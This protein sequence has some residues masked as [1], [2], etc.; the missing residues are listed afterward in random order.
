MTLDQVIAG[1]KPHIHTHF[2]GKEWPSLNEMK[3][4]IVPYNSA[5]WEI[6][7]NKTMADRAKAATNPSRS[8]QQPK[9]RSQ[10]QT[11]QIKVE[12][13]KAGGTNRRFLPQD[14]FEECKKNRWCFMCKADGLKIIGSAK[15]HPNHLPQTTKN[16]DK[17]TK[18]T[19]IAAMDGKEWET[20]SCADVDSDDDYEE[21][22]KN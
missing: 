21:K 8:S 14:E 22:S 7:K 2:I 19:K 11:P 4:E 1:L 12:V 13:S 10:S 20:V 16:K 17:D 15:F 5:F 9:E 18:S 3:S 6:N